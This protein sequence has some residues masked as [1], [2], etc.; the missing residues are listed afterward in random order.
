M[1]T[2][3]T[4]A[5]GKRSGRCRRVNTPS[6]LE[7]SL[8]DASWPVAALKTRAE[9]RSRYFSLCVLLDT[10]QSLCSIFWIVLSSRLFHSRGIQFRGNRPGATKFATR[11]DQGSAKDPQPGHRQMY[12]P[13]L[14]GHKNRQ[15]Y[16]SC[17]V[18]TPVHSSGTRLTLT[19]RLLT[20]DDTRV[21]TRE[22][23]KIHP[24]ES[25]RG[26][27]VRRSLCAEP[28]ARQDTG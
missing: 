9:R 14:V 7:C 8:R 26:Q 11:R 20:A 16:L 6:G 21:A 10:R 18:G 25:S 3:T 24:G 22:S 15:M 27:A 19:G 12:L 17:L 28:D 5:R 4:Q 23:P 2:T 13:C 1:S